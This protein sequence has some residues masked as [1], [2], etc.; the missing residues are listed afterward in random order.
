MSIQSDMSLNEDNYD[1]DT[2]GIE[3]IDDSL[4]SGDNWLKDSEIT[5]KG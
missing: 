4:R 5:A 1:L 2:V 3:V